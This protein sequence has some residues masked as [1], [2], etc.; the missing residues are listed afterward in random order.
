MRNP[1]WLCCH[2]LKKQRCSK[3]DLKRFLF[4]MGNSLLSWGQP[5]YLAVAKNF[6]A[7]PSQRVFCFYACIAPNMFFA[8]LLYCIVCKL[9]FQYLNEKLNPFFF[10]CF[11]WHVGRHEKIS[12]HKIVVLYVHWASLLWMFARWNFDTMMTCKNNQE[13]VGSWGLKIECWKFDNAPVKKN[14]DHKVGD[15]SAKFP[16]SA[17]LLIIS[18]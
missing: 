10:G 9:D 2:M 7:C 17:C 16:F 8:Q 3:R 14:V 6:C 18:I 5:L 12:F 4:F 11:F 15:G 13:N 1:S